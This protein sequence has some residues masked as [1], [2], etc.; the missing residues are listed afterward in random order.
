M[1]GSTAD[2]YI[3][4]Y[5]THTVGFLCKNSQ[6]RNPMNYFQ[7]NVPSHMIDTVV[8][9]SQSVTIFICVSWI[10][11]TENDEC[12]HLKPIKNANL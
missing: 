11:L 5:Q 8:N 10:L 1:K 4:P 9:T 12:K 7:K 3:G 6:Q 2:V